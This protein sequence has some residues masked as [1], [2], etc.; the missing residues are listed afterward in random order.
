MTDAPARRRRW[1]RVVLAVVA[2]LVVATVAALLWLRPAG[3]TQPALDA[4]RTDD[5]VHV[6]E[7]SA[8]VVLSPTG[9]ASGTGLF[10]QPGARV[11][12]RAYA[13]VLR[14]LAESG[15]EVVIAKQPL[16]IAFLALPAFD[17]A[18]A[19]RPHIERWVVGGH[20]L[21][22]TVAGLHAEAAAADGTVAGLVLHA[23]YPSS[24]LSALAIPVLSLSGGG[25][26]I[27]TPD[28]I[29]TRRDLLPPATTYTQLPGV[30]HAGF[31]DYGAQ[32]GDGPLGVTQDE[33]RAAVAAATLAFVERVSG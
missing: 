9:D 23:S 22:G 29:A 21:G 5:R 7:D 15:H 25:D 1:P 8:R 28:D 20:S 31:G 3:P 16:G 13:A 14:P 6:A 19:D 32:A 26:A 18:R 33:A 27:T 12:A 11:D 2:V 10:F 17:A 24:D 4:L 30:N